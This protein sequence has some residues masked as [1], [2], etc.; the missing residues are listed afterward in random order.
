MPGLAVAS[1]SKTDQCLLRQF[2]RRGLRYFLE[3]Q[4]VDG[5]V[6][7]RQSNHGPIRGGEPLSLSATGMG[8][9]A[10]ALSSA[11]PY[12]LIPRAEAIDRVRKAVETGLNRVP[13]DRGILPHFVHPETLRPVGDDAFSTVDT[14]WFI[15]GALWAAKFLGDD[16]LVNLADQIYKRVDWRYWSKPSNSLEP[17]QIR[18]GKNG[19]G[20]FLP[21]RWDRANGE[22]VMM[23]VL[24]AGADTDRAMPGETWKSLQPFYGEVAG[25]RF[26]NADLGLFVFQYGLDLL[27]LGRW[28]SPTGLDL[29]AEA[30]IAAMANHDACHESADRFRTYRVHWGL[31]AG[32]GPGVTTGSDAYCDYSPSKSLDGTAHLTATLASV[33]HHPELVLENIRP[34]LST[35]KT[36]PLGRYGLS[37]VNRDH[38]WVGRDMVG[39]DAGALVL[40]LDNVL[41]EDRVRTVFHEIASVRQG[42]E[43]LGFRN[44]AS[45]RRAS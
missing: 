10:I 9:I 3:N 42:L 24:A 43:R 21:C 4:G 17:W 7:D 36:S 32:D 19:R 34:A 22:T 40:A 27:D 11:E 8:L 45:L 12:H 14:S 18:H 20:Q 44:I 6:Q 28:Q 13:N 2:Q 41:V 37:C 33:A 5:L 38:G 1:I 39:I 30:G 26:N 31:S 23:Y 35:G 25:Y 29:M 15:A 16:E